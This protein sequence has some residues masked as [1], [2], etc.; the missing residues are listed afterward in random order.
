MTE[1]NY[2]IAIKRL[3]QRFENGRLVIQSYIRVLLEY[4]QGDSTLSSEL[5]ALYSN[6]VSYLAALEALGQ[7]VD[8]W[9]S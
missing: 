1:T 2:S 3:Q 5:K 6:V 9:Y 7:P 8:R 4:P